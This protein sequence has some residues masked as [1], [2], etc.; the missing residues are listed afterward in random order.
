LLLD[1]RFITDHARAAGEFDRES[2]R[3]IQMARAA[4]ARRWPRRVGRIMTLPRLWDEQR[5]GRELARFANPLQHISDSTY[6][7]GGQDGQFRLPDAH[8]DITGLGDVAAAL[9]GRVR[10]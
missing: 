8:P 2:P 7:A 5:I 1:G 6:Q 9:A 4:A 3:V 10:N